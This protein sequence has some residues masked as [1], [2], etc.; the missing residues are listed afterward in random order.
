M[1]TDGESVTPGISREPSRFEGCALPKLETSE[2][3][4]RFSANECCFVSRDSDS[5]A[6]FSGVASSR[7]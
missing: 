5:E 2:D 1:V 4:T 7:S 6:W 3:N